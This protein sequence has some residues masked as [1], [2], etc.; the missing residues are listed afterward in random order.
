VV[1]ITGLALVVL[2][3]LVVAGCG[4]PSGT[5][6][7][8]VTY[9]VSGG[10][11]GWDR[12]LTV[13]PDGSFTVKVV[14]GP[15]PPAGGQKVDAAVLQRLHE[16]VSD[17]AFDRLDAAYLPGPGGADLQDYVVTAE[18]GGRT[19]QKMSRDGANVPANLREV[20]GILNGILSAS[21]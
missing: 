20:Q 19:I 21:A 4:S 2:S 1:K 7:G 18:V 15:S 11:T 17:P 14:R 5:S 10:I 13:E 12:I 9:E 6:V 8:R 3:V 16:L